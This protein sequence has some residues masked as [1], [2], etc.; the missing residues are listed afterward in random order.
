LKI[1]RRGV[2]AA[3]IALFSVASLAQNL[4]QHD[5]LLRD[6][7]Q[8]LIEINTTDSA[9]DCTQAAQAMAARL[10]AGGFSDEQM[11]IIVPPGGPKK[12]NLVARLKGSGTAKALMLLA[13]IDVVEAKREDWERDPFKLVEENGFFYARGSSDDKP[14]AAINVSNMIRFKREGFVPNR[15]IILALTCDEELA[16]T[17]FN[18]VEYL[19]KH[20]RNLIDAEL[21]LNEGGGGSMDKS[22][23]PVLHGIQAGEKTYQSFQLEVTNVGGHSS[24]PVKNNAIYHLADGLSRLGKFE[25]PFKLSDTTRT[26]FQ[27]RAE[28]EPPPVAAD[29]R[30]ILSEPPDSGALA[31]LYAVSPYYNA[32][33]RTTCVATMLDAGHADNALPQRA[34]ARVNCRILPDESVDEVRKTLASVL[35]DDQIRITPMGTATLSPRPPLTPSLMKAVEDITAEMWPGIPVIPVLAAGGTD[36]RFLNNAGIWTYGITGMFHYPEGSRAHGLNER[37]PVKS[38]YDAHEFQ[39]RLA[40]RLASG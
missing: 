17:Q 38:F 29:M 24:V 4:P 25:F 35:A 6:I 22:G 2:Y 27:R 8:E 10:K 15:D 3:C 18:G 32:A 9:G 13:H 36:G 1:I 26:Y 37:L 20:H 7:Y 12:G 30:A 16:P 34:R 31:R 21:A 14:M 28:L 40:K 33:V 19:L 23:K 11:Q 39:Y 5:K